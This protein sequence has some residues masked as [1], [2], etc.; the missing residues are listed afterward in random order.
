MKKMAIPKVSEL[1]KDSTK[2]SVRS[3]TDTIK[4][5]EA[6]KDQAALWRA[7]ALLQI[8]ATAMAL[9]LALILWSTRSITLNVPAKPLP[10]V[11]AV[12]ELRDNEFI[13]VA[14]EFINLVATYKP[15]VARRQFEKASEM[16]IEPMLSYFKTNIL[17]DEL[18]AIETTGRTQFF[19][20]DPSKTTIQRD[21]KNVIVVFRGDRTKIIGGRDAPPTPAMYEITMTTI[22]RN[23]LNPYGIVISNVIFESKKE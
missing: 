18:K 9:V 6:Y 20:P 15:N 7:I 11:Y 23:I 14:T 12:H 13:N 17:N 2:Q 1:L 5:W 8:P 4:I 19:F 21:G 22:P 16:L 10:G 3:E